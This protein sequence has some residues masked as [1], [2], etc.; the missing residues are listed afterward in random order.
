MNHIVVDYHILSLTH[1]VMNIIDILDSMYDI[2]S[3]SYEYA[4][5]STWISEQKIGIVGKTN[6]N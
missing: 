1:K 4:K 3:E 2:D 5:I 6:G